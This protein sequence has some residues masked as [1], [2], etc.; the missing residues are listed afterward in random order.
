MKNYR[1]VVRAQDPQT[2]W[3]DGALSLARSEARDLCVSFQQEVFLYKNEGSIPLAAFRYTKGGT[4]IELKQHKLRASAPEEARAR[5][6][7]SLE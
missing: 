5:E 4:V 2:F 3:C 6:A 1:L 7:A